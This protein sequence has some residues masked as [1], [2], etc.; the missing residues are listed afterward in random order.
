[1]KELEKTVKDYQNSRLSSSVKLKPITSD[2][3]EFNNI[4]GLP[5]HPQTFKEHALTNIQVKLF[6]ESVHHT[7]QTKLHLNKARQCGWTETILRVL[8]LITG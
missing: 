4:I 1:M 8:A 7:N 3:L 6:K 2:F 5:K